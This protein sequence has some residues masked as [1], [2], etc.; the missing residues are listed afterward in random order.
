[1]HV[2][3][4]YVVVHVS[5]HVDV[6]ALS[7]MCTCRFPVNVGYWAASAFFTACSSNAGGRSP[8]SNSVS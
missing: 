1:V 6:H 2:H 4:V 5:V 8:W 3:G 7:S